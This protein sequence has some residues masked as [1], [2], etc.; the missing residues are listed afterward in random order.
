MERVLQFTS[1]TYTVIF[2]SVI[3]VI[4]FI[5]SLQTYFNYKRKNLSFYRV[6]SLGFVLL[7][8]ASAIFILMIKMKWPLRS[9]QNILAGSIAF[10][11]YL[12]AAYFL[13]RAIVLEKRNKINK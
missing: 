9:F 2:H 7:G 3:V 11:F 8:I 5:Y 13:I 1:F 6:Y 4:T 12:F 10:L